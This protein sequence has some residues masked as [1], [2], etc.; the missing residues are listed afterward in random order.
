MEHFLKFLVVGTLGFIIN[1]VVLIFGVR[2]GMT[3]SLSGPLGAEL[4]ILSNF[5]L[6]NFWT[7]SDKRLS[8]SDVPVKFITFNV[9]SFGS[10]I[11]Q[12]IF[13][14]TGEKIFG[15]KR[16]KEPFLEM[17]PFFGKFPLIK[18]IL[19]IS[20]V[21]NLSKKFSVYLIFYVM[22]VGVGLVV[23]FIIYSQIIW[24]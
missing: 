16:F 15:L 19:K 1:T 18:D 11:I 7:F 6:N 22:G 21:K 9:L 2:I 10:V 20:F 8:M 13:L 12:F 23:N 17:V 5:I 4:A 14:K 24:K 3:P